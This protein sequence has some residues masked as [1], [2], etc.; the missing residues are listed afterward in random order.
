MADNYRPL[1][2]DELQGL[3]QATLMQALKDRAALFDFFV[4]DTMEAEHY[5][6]LFSMSASKM[7][8]HD[9]DMAVSLAKDFN[10]H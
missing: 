3:D 7:A 8:R 4:P 2:D 5:A 9:I 10:L 6:D 1:S